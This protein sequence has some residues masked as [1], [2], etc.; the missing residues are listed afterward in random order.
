MTDKEL[1]A[2]LKVCYEYL[3]DIRENN[4]NR[5]TD[6]E[7]QMIWNMEEQI[8]SLYQKVF[9][10]AIESEYKDELK[11]EV[12]EELG[13]SEVIIG[14]NVATDYNFVKKGTFDIEKDNYNDFDFATCEDFGVYWYYDELQKFS[15]GDKNENITDKVVEIED[16][17]GNTIMAFEVT[18]YGKIVNYDNCDIADIDSD[19]IFNTDKDL[20]RI[21]VRESDND[22]E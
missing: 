15:K 16:Y 14:S 2:E 5:Y 20:M 13:D 12:K 3:N 8:D 11:I 17:N 18:E 6:E 4:E 9:N 1:L 19:Y 7:E 22:D 21:Q 10:M